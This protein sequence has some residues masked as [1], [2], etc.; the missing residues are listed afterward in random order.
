MSLL[1]ELRKPR[2]IANGLQVGECYGCYDKQRAQAADEIERLTAEIERLRDFINAIAHWP[3]E[4]NEWDGRD[5]FREIREMAL[6]M[7]LNQQQET[8]GHVRHD[9]DF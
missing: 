8:V 1:E 4:E 6:A 5:R 9:P 3:D 7:C 2:E